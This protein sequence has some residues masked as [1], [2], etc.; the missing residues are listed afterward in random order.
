M[1]MIEIKEEKYNDICE[2]AE[3]MIKYATKIQEHLAHNEYNQ[4]RYSDY[5]DYDNDRHKRNYYSRY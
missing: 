5:D 2:Y 4:R 3:K 1:K